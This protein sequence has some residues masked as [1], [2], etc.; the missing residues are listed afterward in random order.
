MH[1]NEESKHSK[2]TLKAIIF[3]LVLS[4]SKSNP[5]EDLGIGLNTQVTA[6]Q[7]KVLPLVSQG[8]SNKYIAK[9]F[10]CSVKIIENAVNRAAQNLNINPDQDLNVRV[11]LVL[12]Y[13][14]HLEATKNNK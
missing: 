3:A 6:F 11:Q 7:Y 1:P 10:E 14:T 4:V 13:K 8:R 12:L 9:K 5:K 2:I